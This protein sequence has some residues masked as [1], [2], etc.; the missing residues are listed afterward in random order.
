MKRL[1]FLYGEQR[2]E[3]QVLPEGKGW[4]VILP[5]G[6]EHCV[7]EVHIGEDGSMRLRTPTGVWQL[8]FHRS[9]NEIALGWHGRVYSFRSA[10]SGTATI[11]HPTA[12][13][14][15][16]APMPG[17]IRKVLVQVGEQVGAGQPLIVLEAMK[18]EQ[19][20]R[21]PYAG[22]VRTLRCREGE[23]VQEGTIL[24]EI[25]PLSGTPSELA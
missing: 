2:I 20:L 3:L 9:G 12:E 21:A 4:R 23:I 16:T 19:T 14:M 10:A 25:E 13:G 22:V 6:S 15:L 17:L 8:F 7:S 18:T 5:D 1:T 11:H 24:V